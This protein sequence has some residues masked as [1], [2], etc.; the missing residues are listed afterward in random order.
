M[1]ISIFNKLFEKLKEQRILHK[2]F[3]DSSFTL[4]MKAGQDSTG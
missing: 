1:I 3:N 4:I 2:S